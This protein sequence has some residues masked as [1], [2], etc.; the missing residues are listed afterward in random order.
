MSVKRSKRRFVR[1]GGFEQD[2][3]DQVLI[4]MPYYGGSYGS[5][6]KPRKLQRRKIRPER[7]MMR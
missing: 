6:Q 3:I 7:A 2:G 1:I 5:N 4:I